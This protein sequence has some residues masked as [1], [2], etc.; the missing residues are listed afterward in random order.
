MK[1]QYIEKLMLLAFPGIL[2]IEK[3]ATGN[4]Y[5][6]DNIELTE[7][8]MRLAHLKCTANQLVNKLLK[9]FFRVLMMIWLTT[10]AVFWQTLLIDLSYACNE[11]DPTKDCFE[12]KTIK[13]GAGS[14]MDQFSAPPVDCDNPNSNISGPVVCYR[15]VF[16]LGL[17]SG[18][19]YGLFKI[20]TVVVN[21]IS[22]GML[23][24][25]KGSQVGKVQAAILLSILIIE[26]IAIAVL[27]S[28]DVPLLKLQSQQMAQ[29]LQIVFTILI[30]G[31]VV[32]FFPWKEMVELKRVTQGDDQPA[33]AVNDGADVNQ[34][35]GPNEP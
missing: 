6:F 1:W 3:K 14:Y 15:L 29:F 18:V 31:C 17:A 9:S 11:N 4:I 23:L 27:Y 33:A 26:I 20:I 5:I 35:N 21:I 16:N 19:S 30:A 25:K 24:A 12:F 10:A 7:V 32:F 13:D 2:K 34:T 28:V 22:L 8:N